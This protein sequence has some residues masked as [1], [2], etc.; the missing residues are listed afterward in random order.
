MNSKLNS[1]AENMSKKF[2]KKTYVANLPLN[3]SICI[4]E[5]SIFD[6]TSPVSEITF[7]YGI[8]RKVLQIHI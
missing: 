4:L 8:L 5:S 2:C 7:T 1:W 6:Q 3:A